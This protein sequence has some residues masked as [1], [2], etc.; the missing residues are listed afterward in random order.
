MTT[1]W[2]D[3]W[4]DTDYTEYKKYI[5]INQEFEYMKYFNKYNIKK[6]CDIG[7][8]FGKY[9]VIS[10]I[11]DCEIYGTDISENAILITTDMIESFN[12]DYKE[13]IKCEITKID[14]KDNMFDGLIAHAVIDHVTFYEARK[15]IKEFSRITKPNGLI[16]ISFDGIESDDLEEKHTILQDGSMFYED[17]DRSGMIFKYYSD[18]N[19][20]DLLDGFKVIYR[21]S[22][23]RGERD[24]IIINK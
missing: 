8:G 22:N 13:Y 3:I 11:N 20:D 9:S 5:D 2:N 15:A 10:G 18:S 7:C 14:F 19:I 24:I 23:N 21:C 16:Y 4:K 17:G 6:I 12:L 1:Y